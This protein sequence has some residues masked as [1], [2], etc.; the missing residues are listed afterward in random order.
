MYRTLDCATEF[1][2]RYKVETLIVPLLQM[3]TLNHRETRSP[4]QNHAVS[5]NMHFVNLASTLSVELQRIEGF[6]RSITHLAQ[7]PLGAYWDCG[8]G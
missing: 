5:N 8:N 6:L 3:R 7:G 4:I 1:S 2:Q